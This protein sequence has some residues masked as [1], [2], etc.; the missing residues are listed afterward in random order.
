[1]KKTLIGISIF[2]FFLVLY[3]LQS[4]FFSWF[5]IAGVKPNLFIIF[6]LFISLFAGIKMGIGFGL[7]SGLFLDIVLGRNVGIYTLMFTAI[8]FLGWYFGKNFSKDSR[9][10][11]MLMVIS[12]TLIFEFGAY[13]LNSIILKSNFEI[14]YFLKILTIEIVYNA[15]ITIILYPLM[16]FIGYKIEEVFRG[17]NILTRYF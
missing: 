14:L 11:I 12:A 7:F 1:M 2:V 6:V 15:I 4:N 5:T 3:F 9:I 10:T 8:A 17:H 16:R 13:V